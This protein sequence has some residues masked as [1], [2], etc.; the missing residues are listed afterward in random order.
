M[1]GYKSQR[2]KELLST[3]H[4]FWGLLAEQGDG[5]AVVRYEQGRQRQRRMDKSAAN[6][7]GDET[8]EPGA[9]Q[10][11]QKFIE[12][13][14]DIA[15][16]HDTEKQQWQYVDAA[17]QSETDDNDTSGSSLAEHRVVGQVEQ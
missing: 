9:E 12:R 17:G 11:E 1:F 5:L 13:E 8:T 3:R 6:T 2:H 14:S 4:G 7:T 16:E 10:L 15:P